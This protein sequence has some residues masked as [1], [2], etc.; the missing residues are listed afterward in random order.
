MEELARQER[1]VRVAS[2]RLELQAHQVAQLGLRALRVRLEVQ[3][4]VGSLA[5]L[6]L[7]A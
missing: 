3:E 5:A 6:E 1:L 2:E 7:Q 4:L